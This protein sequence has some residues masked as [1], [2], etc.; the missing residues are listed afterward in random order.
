MN[1][2]SL[3][4][5]SR[6][7][8]AEVDRSLAKIIALAVLGVIS[9]A[10]SGFLLSRYAEDASALNFW[11]LSGA[12]VAFLVVIILQTLFV[13]SFGKSAVL[14]A[15]YAIALVAPLAPAISLYELAGGG[16]AFLGMLW[17]C[18]IGSR[19]LKD[20]VKIR[21]FRVSSMT[22]GKTATGLSVF[23]A[24]YY[25][26]TQP[27]TAL[28]SK[29]LFEQM[30]LPGASI[31]ERYLPGVSLTGT[32][33]EAATQVAANQA[34]AVPGFELLSPSAQRDL[35]NRAASEF[36][37]QAAD[38][39][40][41]AVRPNARVVDLLYEALTSRL[42]GLSESGRQIALGLIGVSVFFAIRG[43]GVLFVWAA[44]A[45]GFVVYEILIA[46]GFAT[47]VL[48]GASREIIIL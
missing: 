39:L 26:G 30:L 7:N 4:S 19:E 43:L 15:A 8:E 6:T 27:G 46:L 11:L 18:F 35:L 9:A 5:H 25:L 38:L 2:T 21:F 32:L 3:L 31:T 47:V 23:L 16:A 45:L 24:L 44:L 42:A 13:K 41:I 33:R 20:R 29:P 12:L 10:A 17:G 34:K 37:A 36:E 14:N 40:G 28:I 1:Q 48:E 22:L